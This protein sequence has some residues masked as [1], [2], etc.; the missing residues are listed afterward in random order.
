MNSSDNITSETNLNGDFLRKMIAK[1]EALENKVLELEA[2]LDHQEGN[3]PFSSPISISS[4]QISPCSLS[5]PSSHRKENVFGDLFQSG[6]LNNAAMAI[7][8]HT[9][10]AREWQCADIE[11][12]PNVLDRI[13]SDAHYLTCAIPRRSVSPVICL[14]GSRCVSHLLFFR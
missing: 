5:T 14:D 13:L 8:H 10:A 12:C 9:M 3:V 1:F 7:V 4:S 6:K 2:Q 11:D